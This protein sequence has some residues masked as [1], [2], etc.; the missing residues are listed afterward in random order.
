MLTDWKRS[1]LTDGIVGA[2]LPKSKILQQWYGQRTPQEIERIRG[3]IQPFAVDEAKAGRA[4]SKGLAYS[5]K[6]SQADADAL[7]AVAVRRFQKLQ[8]RAAK[9]NRTVG[10]TLEQVETQVSKEYKLGE[11]GGQARSTLERLDQF[12][13]GSLP[14]V[15]FGDE[16][17]LILVP[18]VSKVKIFGVLPKNVPGAGLTRRL[19]AE[20]INF[21]SFG[22]NITDA[23][24]Q[25]LTEEILKAA[26]SK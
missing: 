22:L 11:I 1:K 10:V 23:E 24:L 14:T 26:K 17:F 2:R 8:A 5:Y 16:E 25:S 21:E 6:P 4:S 20:G 3:V 7:K 9:E 15:F 12:E 18:N 19:R 13:D